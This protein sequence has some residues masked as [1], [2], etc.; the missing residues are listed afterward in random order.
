MQ[1]IDL[2]LAVNYL[3]ACFGMVRLLIYMTFLSICTPFEDKFDDRLF[4]IMFLLIIVDRILIQGDQHIF[5]D[6]NAIMLHVFFSNVYQHIRGVSD[7]V[8]FS[9]LLVYFGWSLWSAVV[10]YDFGVVSKIFQTL[11]P[12]YLKPTHMYLSITNGI[13]FFLLFHTAEWESNICRIAKGLTYGVL[14]IAWT[15]IVALNDTRFQLPTDNINIQLVARF[16]PI[17]ILPIWMS[18]LYTAISLIIVVIHLRS[19]YFSQDTN[20]KTDEL[21]SVICAPEPLKVEKL[22][23]IVEAPEEPDIETL[24]RMAKAASME[25]EAGSRAH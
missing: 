2:A 20:K 12:F 17:L 13:L 23:T 25:K 11:S 10:L 8:N 1:K 9:V 14:A 6:G 5:L 7:N 22:P 21:T 3:P 16:L 18:G 15:Y 24:F 4:I 19:V